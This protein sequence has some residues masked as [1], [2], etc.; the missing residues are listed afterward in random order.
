[1]VCNAPP[2]GPDL[3]LT[4]HY[5]FLYISVIIAEMYSSLRGTQTVTEGQRC[6]I[7]TETER[8]RYDRERDRD[9]EK[10]STQRKR[11]TG[12]QNER[13]GSYI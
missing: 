10:K 12:R 13:D 7:E 1:M 8:Q 2:P 5:H 4:K 9:R 3:Y 6:E 11:A